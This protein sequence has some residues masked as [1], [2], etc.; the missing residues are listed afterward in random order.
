MT[1]EIQAERLNQ[2]VKKINKEDG[3][4][5]CVAQSEVH[6]WHMNTD[7]LSTCE[8]KNMMFSDLDVVNELQFDESVTIDKDFK[9]LDEEV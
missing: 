5:G 4:I 3:Y 6:F 9:T 7:L 8:D 1:S 2:I